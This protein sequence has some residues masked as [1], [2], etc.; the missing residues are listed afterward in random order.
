MGIGNVKQHCR[1]ALHKK[2]EAVVKYFRSLLTYSSTSSSSDLSE[3]T[4]KAE[5]L[6]TNIIVQ[7]NL[8]SLH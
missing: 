7:H 2:M 4:I 6:H 3:K 1:S 8:S 5:V